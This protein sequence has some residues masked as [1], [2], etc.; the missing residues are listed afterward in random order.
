MIA[1]DIAAYFDALADRLEKGT[2]EPSDLAAAAA[3]IRDYRRIQSAGGLANSA[4]TCRGLER[5]FGTKPSM[6]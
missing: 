3:I 6:N 1:T 2:A 5:L 4:D